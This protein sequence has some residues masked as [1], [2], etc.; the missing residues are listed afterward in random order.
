MTLILAAVK[1]KFAVIASD[2]AEFRHFKDRPTELAVR[3]RQKLFPLHG[4]SVV[5]GIHGQNRLHSDEAPDGVLV[6]SIIAD[7]HDHLI[8]I[9]EVI[10]IAEYLRDQ[11]LPLFRST[12]NFLNRSSLE[13]QALKILSIGFDLGGDRCVAFETTWNPLSERSPVEIVP[14]D[15]S[16]L[17]LIH[18][19]SGESFVRDVVGKTGNKLHPDAVRKSSLDDT[20]KYV[21]QV[22][23]AA[24]ASQPTHDIKFD[25]KYQCISVNSNGWRWQEGVPSS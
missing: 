24:F 15:C 13:A 25:G 8:A 12:V 14:F 11:L 5:F 16:K 17:R 23:D 10:R 22:Y 2:G 3:D 19:A 21:K 1:P 4:R 18:A 7:Y 9:P 20:K 6:G